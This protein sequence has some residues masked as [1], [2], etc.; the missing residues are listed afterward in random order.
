MKNIPI[1]QILLENGYITKQHLEDALVKQK[2][3]GKKLGDMLLDLG[4]AAR[5]GAFPEV[6]GSLYR[7]YNNQNRKRRC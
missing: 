3:T 6:K 2:E 5:A 1:G 7:P 4:D